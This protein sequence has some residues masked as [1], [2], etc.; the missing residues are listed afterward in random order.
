[1]TN[2]ELLVKLAEGKK[3]RRKDW[4]A[5]DDYIHMTVD[6]HVVNSRGVDY[7][8]LSVFDDWQEIVEPLR[9]EGNCQ[10]GPSLFPGHAYGTTLGVTLPLMF[11]SK[12]V[13]V[14]V[15]EIV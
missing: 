4:G 7:S 6:G 11:E 12:R 13:K 14:I 2:R 1:M 10:V 15:E 9:W 8:C 3:F 5:V